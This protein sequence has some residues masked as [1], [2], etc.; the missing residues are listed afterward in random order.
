MRFVVAG[1]LGAIGALVSGI[2]ISI[3]IHPYVI[4][5]LGEFVRPEAQGPY[6]PSLLSGYLVLGFAMAYL[7]P[8][9]S[10]TKMSLVQ[11]LTAGAAIGLAV[12]FAGHLITSG[13][14][15]LPAGVMAVSGLFDSLSIVFGFWVV[16]YVYR[17][18][19]GRR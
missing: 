10:V 2:V 9:L 11:V 14:S 7:A 6:F 18:P 1:V 17:R 12:F 15:R 4:P 16:A 13:W 8:K 3:P 19:V 5:L